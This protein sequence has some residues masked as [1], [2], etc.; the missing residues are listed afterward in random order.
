MSWERLWLCSGEC[1]ST[2]GSLGGQLKAG[3]VWCLSVELLPYAVLGPS[4]W[5]GPGG[6]GRVG[7]EEVSEALDPSFVQGPSPRRKCCLEVKGC[8]LF[9]YCSLLLL[10]DSQPVVSI[11]PTLT[12]GKHSSVQKRK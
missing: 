8:M 10:G 1:P 2:L 3:R 11:N 4:A 12:G 5:R 7:T 9:P 6:L